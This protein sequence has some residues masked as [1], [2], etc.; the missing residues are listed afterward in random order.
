MTTSLREL[1]AA[2][3][4]QGTKCAQAF[5]AARDGI[6]RELDAVGGYA[7]TSPEYAD[8]DGKTYESGKGYCRD[9]FRQADSFGGGVAVVGEDAGG[10]HA[11]KLT[12]YLPE[13]GDRCFA[14]EQ[15]WRKE[16][17]AL[18]A[19][20]DAVREHIANVS[21]IKMDA[22]TVAALAQQGVGPEHVAL[23]LLKELGDKP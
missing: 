20:V 8:K 13:V 9:F 5:D 3:E 7:T 1:V 4:A 15:A 18:T 22:G 19:T 6:N 10:A 11:G 2:W 21:G 17:M 16:A 14:L 23:A 12:P